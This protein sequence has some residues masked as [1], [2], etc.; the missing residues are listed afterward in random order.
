MV[1][2]NGAVLGT[3]QK[4]HAMFQNGYPRSQGV[5]TFEFLIIKKSAC[6]LVMMLDR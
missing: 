5:G 4:N 1:K 2:S 6:V 3:L